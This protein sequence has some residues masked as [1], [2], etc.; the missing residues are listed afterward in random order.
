MG[1]GTP[2]CTKQRYHHG[3]R[4]SSRPAEKHTH[5]AQWEACATNGV[6]G[7]GAMGPQGP[8]LWGPS[9]KEQAGREGFTRKGSCV[10]SW[11]AVVWADAV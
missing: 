6:F 8:V 10:G 3:E 1:G 9:E 7:G 4:V 2:G 11:P 5:P